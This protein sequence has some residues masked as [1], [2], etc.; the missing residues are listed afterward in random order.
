MRAA[1]A[2][3]VPPRAGRPAPR[4]R[5]T[6]SL[7]RAEL[8]ARAHAAADPRTQIE[9][10]RLAIHEAGHAV[11]VLMIGAGVDG[12]RVV[13]DD[14]ALRAG[15]LELLRGWTLAVSAG[16]LNEIV[17]AAGA[18]AEL[19]DMRRHRYPF[20]E[21]NWS[22]DRERVAEYQRARG[23][24]PDFAAAVRHAWQ[25]CARWSR[26]I[27]AVASALEAAGELTGEDAT[28]L[29]LDNLPPAQRRLTS[30]LYA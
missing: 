19:E 21:P 30:G 7:T 9:A 26:S 20:E 3:R 22:S 28:A 13:A 18:A 17:L 11:G 6:R 1:A 12:V 29:I 16:P 15:R 4:R 5:A 10:R 14:D 2:V 27:E 25:A 8:W 23:H 24:R